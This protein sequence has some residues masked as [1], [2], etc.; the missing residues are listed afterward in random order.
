MIVNGNVAADQCNSVVIEFIGVGRN[1]DIRN[2]TE[3]ALLNDAQIFG[4]FDCSNN[5]VGCL[6]GNSNVNGN[7]QI[8]NNGANSVVGGN[9]IGGTLE[10]SGNAQPFTAAPSPP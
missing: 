5:P 6:L 7:V 1:V 2:C 8:T 4:N 9:T 10:C 3:N